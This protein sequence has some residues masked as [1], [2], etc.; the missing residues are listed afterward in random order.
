M[1]AALFSLAYSPMHI[2]MRD[3]DGTCARSIIR[4]WHRLHVERLKLHDFVP[5]IVP[6]ADDALRVYRCAVRYD[7]I[8]AIAVL[9]DEKLVGVAYD[10]AELPAA[11]ALVA[12]LAPHIDASDA[13]PRWQ[14]EAS[15]AMDP[16]ESGP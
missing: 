6:H 15:F 1:F 4:A 16:T 12:Q 5:L 11:S 10:V 9:Q 3:I 8:R 13:E 7:E 2:E 14:C